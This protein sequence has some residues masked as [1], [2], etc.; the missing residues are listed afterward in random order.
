MT[1]AYCYKSGEW[2][3]RPRSTP[4]VVTLRRGR[5]GR[6]RNT[7]AGSPSPVAFS[8][9]AG[10]NDLPTRP[11]NGKPVAAVGRTVIR[12]NLFR[13]F[14]LVLLSIAGYTRRWG[15]PLRPFIPESS[16]T[17]N[18]VSIKNVRESENFSTAQ[19]VGLTA[20]Q[21]AVAALQ[22]AHRG[23]LRRLGRE[24]HPFFTNETAPA[25]DGNH[26]SRDGIHA[27]GRRGEVGV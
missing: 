13:L 6:S 21:D 18:R 11:R 22:Q 5:A 27:F 25:R 14:P 3:P 26:R 2:R 10:G 9:S 4:R 8:K 17:F 24:I 1:G 19:V 20:G 23:R 7:R 15:N 16:S 12:Q